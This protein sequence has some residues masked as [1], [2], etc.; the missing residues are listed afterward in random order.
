[1]MCLV[2]IKRQ[3]S[4]GVEVIEKMAEYVKIKENAD[5]HYANLDSLLPKY[6]GRLFGVLVVRRCFDPHLCP[7]P[8][9]SSPTPHS[10]D[11]SSLLISFASRVV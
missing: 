10:T 11:A 1:M 4:I 2:E 6:R 8:L 9:F 3:K 7:K 5:W